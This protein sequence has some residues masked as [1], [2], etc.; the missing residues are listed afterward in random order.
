MVSYV[1]IFTSGVFVIVLVTPIMYDIY[2]NHLQAWFSTAAPS[3][4]AEKVQTTKA[5][6]SR[7]TLT[8]C[9]GF[10]GRI[11][12]LMFQYASG[13][14]IAKENK[15]QFLFKPKLAEKLQVYFNILQRTKRSE[16]CSIKQL[17]PIGHNSISLPENTSLEISGYL[18]SWK[19]F[20]KY[21]SDVR[22]LFTLK[23]NYILQAKNVLKEIQS[24][25]T[26]FNPSGL[27][28]H[29]SNDTSFQ[30]VAIHVRLTDLYKKL[31]DQGFIDRSMKHIDLKFKNVIFI[32]VSD[33]IR[34]CRHGYFSKMH[35]KYSSCKDAGCDLALMSFSDVVIVS[36]VSTFGW[37]GA[38][39]SNRYVIYNKNTR[40]MNADFWMP[41]W[42]GL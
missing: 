2:Y 17:V 7:P 41:Q 42:I 36:E 25:L 11:G 29:R 28:S 12:N 34:K 24:N 30:Y 19:F 39:L 6:T 4:V 16:N 38:W 3:R 14:G 33:D 18:Q 9:A 20:V 15:R 21:T 32:I 22:S 10:A 26:K 8:I 23:R 35:V 40:H 13:Y 31:P 37:W 27:P 1:R 5:V